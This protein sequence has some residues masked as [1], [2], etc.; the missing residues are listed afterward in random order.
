M[1]AIVNAIHMGDVF[2]MLVCDVSP[3]AH[4]KWFT[5]VLD[6]YFNILKVTPIQL[7]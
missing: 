4:C 2:E 5:H 7:W 3:S 1:G 6:E